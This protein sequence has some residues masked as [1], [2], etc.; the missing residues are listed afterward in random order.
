MHDDEVATD[1]SLVRRLLAAQ[2]PH[3]AA[4]DVAPVRAD[5]TDN[6]MYRL[7]DAL[8]VRL[9]RR[10]SA[11]GGIEKEYAWLPRLAPFLPLPLP[12]PL[13]QGAPGEGHPWPWS[14]CRWLDGE[15]P[16]DGRVSDMNRF[17]T[18]LAGFIRAL[19][20]IDARGGPRAGRRNSGRGAP[21]AQWQA[22]IRERLGSLA[23]LDTIDLITAAWA[24]DSKA[25]P[26]DRAAVYI[27]GDLSVGN[28]LVR[29]GTLSGV[30][31]WGCLG[32]GDPACELQVAW[33]LF[34]RDGRA[35]FKAAMAV[36]EATWTRGRAWGLAVG[37]LNMSYYRTRSPAI[38]A[39]GWRAIEAVLVD[40]AGAAAG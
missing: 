1:A 36:D 39:Q 35:A 25:P 37:V 31:D 9:P 13:A 11:V 10:P 18:D 6:A 12:L 21:L 8:A 17:G 2:F 32:A 23:D 40:I 4:L 30:I 38:A 22:T 5:G 27:H 14:V 28:L 19:Q 16:T 24:A 15:N 33:S 20:A 26:W 3:W 7:G 29:A 34:D